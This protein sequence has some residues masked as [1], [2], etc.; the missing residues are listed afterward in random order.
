MA[1]WIPVS[2][3]IAGVWIKRSKEQAISHDLSRYSPVQ[4]ST[5]ST[6]S[7]QY[8]K[9]LVPGDV[10]WIVSGFRR[11][12]LTQGRGK[13]KRKG[14]GKWKRGPQLLVGP[15]AKGSARWGTALYYTMLG[16]IRSG[17]SMP[18]ATN[19]YVY[20][21]NADLGKDADDDTSFKGQRPK[22]QSQKP[23]AKSQSQSQRP[24][25]K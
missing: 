7:V 16:E 9:Y 22:A 14:K 8:R 2:T 17:Y 11:S 10:E 15:V 20:D 4:C 25:A 18:A 1:G 21:G 19:F 23:K 3:G 24:K 13:G 6:Y 12:E 5:H